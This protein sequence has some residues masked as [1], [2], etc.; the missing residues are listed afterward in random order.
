M[1]DSR[2]CVVKL[3][4]GISTWIESTKE[5]W[6][7]VFIKKSIILACHFSNSSKFQW[8]GQNQTHPDD[9]NY[10]Y[11]LRLVRV[12]LRST[13]SINRSKTYPKIKILLYK[14]NPYWAMLPKVHL[15]S[16]QFVE[17][18]SSFHWHFHRKCQWE[19]LLSFHPLHHTTPD[20]LYFRI[21]IDEEDRNERKATCG[22]NRM[23]TSEG[24]SFI[25]WST[26]GERSSSMCVVRSRS[27]GIVLFFWVECNSSVRW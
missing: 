6:M 12:V 11:L 1:K 14:M 19:T 2:E 5:R 22:I 24:N 25:N 21:W 17:R 7:L 4:N 15:I 23:S 26:T 9:Q 18:Q 10:N 13:P 27:I 3:Y 20:D 8:E 16:R